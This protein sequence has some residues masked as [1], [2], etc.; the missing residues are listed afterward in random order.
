MWE[1]LSPDQNNRISIQE[2]T[3]EVTLCVSRRDNRVCCIRFS[4]F[5]ERHTLQY[6]GGIP[7]EPV[8]I[9]ETYHL[10]WGKMN[11]Y[12][13]CGRE[14]TV[15]YSDWKLKVRADN[16]GIAFRYELTGNGEE[17]VAWE[18]TSIEFEQNFHTLYAQDLFPTYERPYEK[19]NWD[20]ADN[21]QL[22]MPVLLQGA[23][24]WALASEADLLSRAQFCSSHWVGKAERVLSLEFA[25]E[26]KG[27]PIPVR[28]PFL[29]PWRY[30]TLA[31]DLNE[32]VRSHFSFDLCEPS[33]IRDISWIRPA[34][35]LWSWWENENGAQLYTES[36]HYVDTAS[37]MG[38]EA[39]T[40]DCGWDANWV[41]QLCKYA[42]GKGVQ[43]WLWTDR[44]RIDT[45]EKMEEYLPLWASWGIDGIKVDFFENDSRATIQAYQMIL[46]RTA[47]LHLMV[48]FHGATKPAGDGRTWPH[49]MT[50]EGIM[51][52]EHYKWSDMP[53]AV[54]NCTVPFTRN[55]CGPMDYTPVGYCN[56]NRNTTHAHQ[57]ALSVVFESGITHY[58]LSVY[59]LE[60]W[61][62]TEFLRH[63]R[64][65]YDDL[66][67]L[68]GMPGQE[69]AV[70]RKKGN[71]YFVGMLTARKQQMVL[72]LDFLPQGTFQ[73]E[74]YEDDEKD[75]MLSVRRMQVD[76][77]KTLRLPLKDC[78]GAVIYIAPEIL[79]DIQD[80]ENVAN[81]GAENC[82]LLHGSEAMRFPDGTPG[83]LLYGAVRVSAVA[84]HSGCCTLRIWYASEEETDISVRVGQW[85]QEYKLPSGGNHFDLRTWDIPM[86]LESNANTLMISRRG[87]GVLTLTKMTLR[88]TYVPEWTVY[89]KESAVLTGNA[90]WN[91]DRQGEWYAS[92][93]GGKSCII[94]EKITVDQTGVYLLRVRYSGGESRGLTIMVNDRET[95]TTYLHSTSGW[96]FP[97]WENVE[98]KEYFVHLSRG[99][100]KIRLFSDAGKMSHIR[101]IGI[102]A[103]PDVD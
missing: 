40:L 1:L 29:S 6:S 97:T 20:Q 36:R 17:S 76:S 59:H 46:E 61:A 7:S 19:R 30:V 63:T 65:V 64:P 87:T 41:P 62:G 66:Q 86:R 4:V 57:L 48:N 68:K 96:G 80:T 58:A 51:G 27:Q 28:L 95:I 16:Q 35:A 23:H 34:R 3:H 56:A 74:I 67:L 90:E 37:E 88:T 94:F 73:A 82:E 102:A 99:M 72:P 44:H 83:I 13:A 45:R 8:S 103:Y 11:T 10:P 54:H 14:M 55:V 84:M 9:R 22:G 5:P 26:E 101:A 52:I 71:E 69:V 2:G 33:R 89:G 81:F 79:S 100:N 21:Q 24:G 31:D 49:L 47:E 98:Y 18:N 38:F 93:L 50:S 77:G 85:E 78:G 60:A 70:M 75:Q 42:H 12:F 39:V 32:L 43:I 92:G 91:L 15:T 25:A 53:D